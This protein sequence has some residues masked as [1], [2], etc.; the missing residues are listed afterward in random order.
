MR[1]REFIKI[2]A[3]SAA[4]WPL[5]ARAQQTEVP[6]VGFIHTGSSS[7]FR[8]LAD[9]FREGLKSA[10]FADGQ[11]VFVDYRWSE[12][13]DERLPQLAAE[14]VQ[15]GVAVIAATGGNPSV[16]AAK[17]ATT[18]IPIVFQAGS[19]PVQAG[20]VSSLSRPT[21]NITGVSI[22]SP[23]LVA[24]RLEVLHEAMPRARHIAFLVN[25]K[26]PLA[27]QET[28]DV[29]A[30]ARALGLIIHPLKVL[31]VNAFES[32]FSSFAKEKDDAVVIASDPLFTSQRARLVGL[33]AQHSLPAIYPFR[34][35]ALVGGLVSFGA[36][37]SEAFRQ[38]GIYTGRILKG[39]K[40]TDLPVQLPTKFE[41]V[42]NL[43]TAKA[44][45]FT[46]PITLLGRADEVIE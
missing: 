12:G 16:V 39:E 31:D 30:A 28:K 2:V 7:A 4:A 33:S 9:A 18:T 46:F 44:L 41:F 20:F 25:P 27:E 14:L 10:G 22:I 34:E 15:R 43:K 13:R 29:E 17:A 11:N 45:G 5:S 35:F 1:R 3:G 21:G 37:I 8:Y 26:S 6:V 23:E 32:A 38:A 24:K 40:P 42:I 36:S 19:D